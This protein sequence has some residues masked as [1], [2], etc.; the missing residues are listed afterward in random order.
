MYIQ[1]DNSYYHI[2]LNHIDLDCKTATFRTTYNVL[3]ARNET[4][5]LTKIVEND[6]Q[7]YYFKFDDL[8]E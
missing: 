1:L 8:V 5:V 2:H 3:D 7:R 6:I 4:L